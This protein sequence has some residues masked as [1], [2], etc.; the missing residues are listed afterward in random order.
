MKISALRLFNV[1]RFAGRG[2]AIED[3]GDGVNVL[4]AANEFGK[5]TSF[6][7]LHALFFQPHSGTPGDVQ[8]LRPY[9]GGNPLIEADITTGDGRFR[10]TKQYYGGRSARVVHL[11]SGRLVAQSDEAEN[12]ITSLTRGGTSGPAGLLWVRQGITGM[13]KRS[14]TEEEGEKQVRQTLL[15]SVQGEVE[16]VTGG[17]RMAEI[18]AAAK[19]ALSVMVTATGRPKA[20][21]RF[22]AV[23]EERERLAED[24]ARLA[25]QVT[26]LRQALDERANATARLAELD[27]PA[28]REERKAAIQKAQ[29]R[30]D[31]AKAQN[32][33]LKTAEAELKLVRERRNAAEREF[34]AF[35]EAREKEAILQGTLSSAKINR[36]EAIKRRREAADAIDKARENVELAE[37][38]EQALR[39]RLARFDAATKAREAHERLADLK[40]RLGEAEKVRQNIEEGE[41]QLALLEISARSIEE[42]QACEV[43]IAK[44]RAI[45]EAARPSVSIHYEADAAGAVTLDGK[46]LTDGEDRTY[47]GQA[48]LDVAGIGTITL[49]SNRLGRDGTQ[50]AQAEAARATLLASMSVDSLSAARERRGRAQQAGADLRGLKDRLSFIAPEGLARLR[51]DVAAGDAISMEVLDLN[52]DPTLLRTALAQAE[53]C[54]KQARLILREVEP[55]QSRADEAFVAAE[56]SLASL[57]AAQAQ[58]AAILGPDEARAERERSLSVKLTELDQSLSEVET[59][60]LKLGADAGDLAS[61]EAALTRTRSIEAAVDKE[62]N[63]LRESMAGLNAEIR[64]QSEEAV[65]EKWREIWR[66]S[67]QRVRGWLHMRRRW[68]SCSV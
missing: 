10:I 14:R 11:G 39:E 41:A 65:E 27:N 57:M 44:L 5:S 13:E 36:A 56:T 54:R 29:S 34:K 61:V 64:A 7:A 52:E 17:R 62:I 63:A 40:Q 37:A 58:L 25:A 15:E 31:A 16:A 53:E 12:F 51:E 6:E 43:E 2:V 18:M 60:F 68:L 35:A 21:G 19:E 9:S 67:L 32:E 30:F 24:E 8:R 42:L 47:D 55:D 3:I 26:R 33:K 49:R 22:A 59:H 20:G 50:M 28:E 66:R 46:P 45:D 4:C 23:I 48:R 38:E 1:K